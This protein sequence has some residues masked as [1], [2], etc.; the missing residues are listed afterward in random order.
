M[1]RKPATSLRQIL[2]RLG[3]DLIRYPAGTSWGAP[4]QRVINETKPDLLIDVGAFEG[5]FSERCREL[6]FG[7]RILSFEPASAAAEALARRAG[8]DPRWTVRRLAIGDEAG[9]AEL[10]VAETPVLNSLLQASREGLEQ[11]S[12]IATRGTE[13]VEVARLDSVVAELAP[14]ARRIFLKID[15]QGYDMRVLEG[16]AGILDDLV[17]IHIE[18]SLQPFYEGSTDYLNVLQ[19][20]RERRFEPVDIVPG[21]VHGSFLAEADCLLQRRSG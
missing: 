7:G 11:Y 1:A 6:G 12:S 14:K 17:A 18:L 9:E 2:H 16:A 4:L 20:L 19:W 10:Y 5:A 3:L 15:A 21:A 13:R 8:Q